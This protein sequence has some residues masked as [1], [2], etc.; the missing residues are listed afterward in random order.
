MHTPFTRRRLIQTTPVVAAA[1]VMSPALITPAAAYAQSDQTA[2]PLVV[3]DAITLNPDLVP[4]DLQIPDGFDVAPATLNLPQGFAISLLAAGLD[5][6]RFMA[7][8]AAGNL[9]VADPA[10]RAVFRYPAV[11]G[12]IA[13]SPTPPEPL[14]A[15]LTAPSNIA[16]FA[17]DDVEY[18]YVGETNQISRYAYDPAGSPGAQEIVV[19]DLPDGGNHRTRTVAFGPDGMLYVAIGSSCNICAEDDDRRAAIMRYAPDGGAEVRFAWGLRNPVGLAIQPGSDR[20]WTSVNERDDQGDEIPPDLITVVQEG[21]NYGWPDC[22]P[23]S[24]TPQEE[25]VDCSG[26]TPP[27]VGIQAHSAPLGIAF[28]TGDTF[29]ADLSGSLFVAQHG[30]WNRSDPAAPKLLRIAFDGD[31]PVSAADFA[32]GWQDE[33]GDRWGRPAGVLVAPDGALI[34]SDDQA[35]VLYRIA[36]E[37]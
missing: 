1:A 35:G 6:P 27:T 19:P 24:A 21:A 20:L 10:A 2:A 31:A 17:V 9:L 16:L 22:Q 14:L 11:D 12:A 13:S 7:Y 29:P 30:S 32:T 4:V 25:G 36:Y 15:D 37:A 23:P 8:D 3:D 18:L 5:S 34:V 33:D 28:Y 26:I